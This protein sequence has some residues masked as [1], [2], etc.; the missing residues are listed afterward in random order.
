[1]AEVKWIKITTNIFDD[2]K[3]KLIDTMPDR[4]ALIVIWFKLLT[5]AGKTN[6]NGFLYIMKEMP[7][8]DEMLATIFNRPLNTVRLALDMFKKFGMIEINTHVN[9]VNWE[10]H[11]NIEGL[12]KIKEQNRLRQQ[13]FKEKQ[14]TL[15]LEDKKSNVT[16]TL[17]NATDIDLELDKELDK[18][19]DIEII[20]KVVAY[21]NEKIDS[22]YKHTSSKT[23]DLIKA[24]LN[25]K[26]TL[27][28]FKIVIDKKSHE[29]LKDEKM[30]KFLRPETLFGTKF[31]S[32]LNQKVKGYVNKQQSDKESEE[33]YGF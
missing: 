28:E 2:E 30:C 24:R 32:Y 4:D 17:S 11:Q 10:K 9:I 20:K 29:W 31:E 33:K 6:D 12:D 14:K 25:Q 22:N 21:L 26:H 8:T 7:T 5:M 16:V 13:K 27:E 23:Q 3:I 15:I 19:K 18:E 1:M